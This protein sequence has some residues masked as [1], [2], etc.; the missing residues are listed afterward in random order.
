MG[1]INRWLIFY[2]LLVRHR[3]AK[4]QIVQI[5][6]KVSTIAMYFKQAGL[7]N[8]F[9]ELLQKLC[10]YPS[11]QAPTKITFCIAVGCLTKNINIIFLAPM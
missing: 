8:C 11:K 3:G 9:W 6:F 10:E 2:F 1:F 7:V 5:S 4:K